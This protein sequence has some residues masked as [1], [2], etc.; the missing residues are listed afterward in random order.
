MHP[1]APILF[2][3]IKA[4]DLG[5]L[6]NILNHF[7]QAP[8]F[9]YA[10]TR[11]WETERK[12]LVISAFEF[13]LIL[14][15]FRIANIFLEKLSYDAF[16]GPRTPE[17]RLS[18]HYALAMVVGALCRQHTAAPYLQYFFQNP[19]D[20]LPFLEESRKK[21]QDWAKDITADS[22]TFQK[23]VTELVNIKPMTQGLI[24]S[25]A[26]IHEMKIFF[27]HFEKIENPSLQHV[28]QE[29]SQKITGLINQPI[30]AEHRNFN[31]GLLNFTRGHTGTVRMLIELREAC[32]YL[33]RYP[34][35][36]A[37]SLEMAKKIMLLCSKSFSFCENPAK[38][39]WLDLAKMIL[40]QFQNSPASTHAL[41]Q[42]LL[43]KQCL[44]TDDGIPLVDSH[45]VCA[46][47]PEHIARYLQGYEHRSFAEALRQKKPIYL[48]H[49]IGQGADLLAVFPLAI[50][51]KCVVV[52]N[53]L[54]NE[55]KEYLKKL[56]MYNHT[57]CFSYPSSEQFTINPMKFFPH[58]STHIFIDVADAHQLAHLGGHLETN[59]YT[60]KE[61]G[62]TLHSDLVSDHDDFSCFKNIQNILGPCQTVTIL[63]VDNLDSRIVLAD[64]ILTRKEM[65][66]GPRVRT[67][68]AHRASI[69][70]TL[71]RKINPVFGEIGASSA[72]SSPS[73]SFV[74]ARHSEAAPIDLDLELNSFFDDDECELQSKDSRSHSLT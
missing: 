38:R 19:A 13:A 55:T 67:G 58:I 45:L 25:F 7:P 51:Q 71:C 23:A 56:L 68:A 60:L 1:Q 59:S 29:L 27:N 20:K 16:L 12:T 33:S 40:S 47:T 3:A 61:M 4:N 48:H 32:D 62:V 46:L 18:F 5:T 22:Q 17:A 50:T 28:V 49:R 52:E 69:H 37:I 21:W 6:K 30:Y 57:L 9:V 2:A 44:S 65:T 41:Y 74:T 34:N 53:Q 72:T 11:E 64:I 35:P 31:L 63:I 10:V 66:P 14:P 42:P 26:L 15:N 43:D 36:T 8:W 24:R 54:D 73:V 70:E 39:I